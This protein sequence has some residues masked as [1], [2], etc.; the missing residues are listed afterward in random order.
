[1]GEGEEGRRRGRWVRWGVMS[2]VGWGLGFE[3][4]VL[5]NGVWEGVERSTEECSS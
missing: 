1:M 5:E 4:L 3:G 2:G